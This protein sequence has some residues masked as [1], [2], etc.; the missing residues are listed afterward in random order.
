MASWNWPDKRIMTD[1]S[2]LIPTFD[3]P[4]KLETCLRCLD[5]QTLGIERYEVVVGVDGGDKAT[6]L[7]LESLRGELGMGERLRWFALPRMGLIGVRNALIGQLAGELLVSINDDVRPEPEFLEAHLIE[8]RR[9]I[10]RDEPAIVVGYSPWVEQ[11]D[12]TM[13]ER[14]VRETS[15]VFFYEHMLGSEAERDWGFRHCFGLNFSAPLDLVREAGGFC[16]LPHTYGYEDLELAHRLTRRFAL[17]VVFRESARAPHDHRMTARGLIERE[18]ALGIAAWRF[19]RVNPQ[20]AFDLFGRDI[21]TREELAYCEAF[22]T[23]ERA[24]V[25][26]LEDAFLT[27]DDMPAAT[28]RGKHAD[29]IVSL[30]GQQWT[31]V[32][33]FHWRR[34]VLDSAM[35]ERA[36]MAMVA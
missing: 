33:R 5:G 8:Q 21:A 34:G 16:A 23:R 18:H 14:L 29:R 13:V 1:L 27:L 7:L 35:M 17:P 11:E 19:A 15:M 12:A 26:R 10:D 2:V 32:K 30:L 3:R 25:G 6:G 20:F 4:D 24:D 36:S 9:R 31:L 22:C 28:L